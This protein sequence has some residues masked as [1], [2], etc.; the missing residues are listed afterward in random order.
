MQIYES[1]END[2]TNTRKNKY[3]MGKYIYEDGEVHQEKS[4]IE[5]DTLV[6]QNPGFQDDYDRVLLKGFNTGLNIKTLVLYHFDLE[7]FVLNNPIPET[8]AALHLINCRFDNLT[9]I[10]HLTQLENFTFTLLAIGSYQ[11]SY[12][13]SDFSHFKSLKTLGLSGV[14]LRRI[15][16]FKGFKNLETLIL[17]DNMISKIEGLE[18]FD[19]L[20]ELHLQCNQIE[21]IEGLDNLH[22]LKRLY[23]YQNKIKLIENLDNLT[24]LEYLDLNYNIFFNEKEYKMPLDQAQRYFGHMKNLIML[25]DNLYPDNDFYKFQRNPEIPIQP[26]FGLPRGPSPRLQ[27]IRERQMER[28]KRSKKV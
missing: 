12:K 18:Q 3:I 15:P 28:E 13:S 23:L 8:V 6:I 14:L 24:R 25:N 26:F 16:I 5:S 4:Y 9:C 2:M 7:N 20:N 21:K 11:F 10:N 27:R 1:R 19:K 22:Q 17:I